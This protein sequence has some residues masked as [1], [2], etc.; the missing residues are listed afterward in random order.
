MAPKL[1]RDLMHIGVTTCQADTPLVE[2][3]R[4]LLGQGLESCI[5]LDQNSHAVG[6][7]GR[8]EAVAAYGRSGAS[9]GDVH[10]LTVA[11]AMQPEILTVPPD[12]PATAAAQIMLDRDVR[13]LYL[14][15]H[16]GG[17][18]WPA[19]DTHLQNDGKLL[20]VGRLAGCSLAR[21]R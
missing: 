9:S 13:E 5:V 7:L 15:H 16:G 4:I 18:S 14:M 12:I 10:S 3:V 21:Q 11:D 20:A 8:R 1:V 17:R 6:V 19:A 2:A